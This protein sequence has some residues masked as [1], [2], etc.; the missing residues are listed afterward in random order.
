MWWSCTWTLSI[1]GKDSNKD[2]ERVINISLHRPV[3]FKPLS[4]VLSPTS[5]PRLQ[6]RQWPPKLQSC[7]FHPWKLYRAQLAVAFGWPQKLLTSFIS[8]ALFTS[9]RAYLLKARLPLL[10]FPGRI[11]VIA[12]PEANT[13]RRWVRIINDQYASN[14]LQMERNREKDGKVQKAV[15]LWEFPIVMSCAVYAPSF[16]TLQRR[17]PQTCTHH[18]HFQNTL[19]RSSTPLLRCVVPKNGATQKLR[20]CYPYYVTSST[21]QGGGGSFKNRKPIGKVGCSESRMAERIHWWTGRWLMSPLFLSLSLSFFDYLPI[22]V[23][24]YLNLI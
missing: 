14:M 3:P 22:Y 17:G 8:Q 7:T 21:A 19:P 23:S 16:S 9:F 18:T 13:S 6:L 4:R 2:T 15:P 5:K 10:E 1:H 20:R 12:S 24:I 11:I